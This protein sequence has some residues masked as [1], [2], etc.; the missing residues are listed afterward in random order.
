MFNTKQI[1]NTL[2]TESGIR[3]PPNT[4]AAKIIYHKDADGFFSALLTYNQLVKQGI[5]PKNIVFYGA[6]YG[7]DEKDTDSEVGTIKKLSSK[8]GQMVSVV[9]FSALPVASIF[10]MMNKAT[11]YAAKPIMFIKFLNVL[12]ADP[13][14]VE[15]KESFK[16]KFEEWWADNPK[17]TDEDI[18][19]IRKALLKVDLNKIPKSGTEDELKKLF[20]VKTHE[21]DFVSDHHD[22]SQDRLSKGKSGGIGKTQYK[23]DTEHLATVYA[24]NLADYSTIKM[25]SM[26]DSAGYKNLMD[27][28]TLPKDF[29]SKG[30]M[31]R[32]AT[33][34]N[35]LIPD[36]LKRNP[37]AIENVIRES[38]PSLVSVYNNIL[39]YHKLNNKQNEVFAELSKSSPDWNKI[40]SIR[41]SL[42]RNMAL[43]TGKDSGKPGEV[44]TVEQWQ[45]KGKED[46]KNA[47]SGAKTGTQKARYEE[48]K[49]KKDKTPEE[50]KELKELGTLKS[51]FMDV[52]FTKGVALRQDATSTRDYPTRYMGSLLQNSKGVRWPI[53]VK[54]FATMIQIAVNPDVD[55]EDKKKIDLI[56]DMNKAKE[57]IK[58]KHMNFSNRWAWEI[59]DQE[60]GGHKQIANLS[61]LGTLGLMKK[62]LRDEYKALEELKKRS[63]GKFQKIMPTK[64]KR[65]MELVD[66]KEKAAETRKEI[67][68]DFEITLYGILK[69]KY[70]DIKIEDKP[71]GLTLKE[72]MLLTSKK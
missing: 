20:K 36:L 26:V 31:E 41:N 23:S 13:K 46:V 18:E 19:N 60:S 28:L 4:H 27:T 44:K 63:G 40:D 69:D 55:I 15:S 32:L 3:I 35:T 7:D 57:I 68:K 50:N 67:M 59:V 43:K 33:L 39:K 56:E 45:E 30:R 58:R 42:P 52:P 66:L 70:G 16:D 22:N 54:R 61:G 47:L 64:Y 29:K 62:D 10:D 2:L 21:P 6:Q 5:N 8:K 1:L 12:K 37:E 51:Q 24:Q 11:N 48:L 17:R 71:T 14:S 49:D 9:D 25:V 38:S 34:L 72:S 53:I 65:F